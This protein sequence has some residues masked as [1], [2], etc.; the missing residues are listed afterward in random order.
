LRAGLAIPTPAEDHR[1]HGIAVAFSAAAIFLPGR[2]R[3]FMK[4]GMRVGCLGM[5][6]ILGGPGVTGSQIL[7]QDTAAETASKRKVKTR[8]QPAY[9]ALAKQLKVTG[10]VRIEVT[11]SPEGR[12]TNTKVVGGNPVLASSAVEAMKKWRFEPGPKETTELIEFE[13]SG[14]S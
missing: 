8:V 12:V 10:K 7:A 14:Q 6:L 2:R 9:P 1:A 5:A 3:A 11:I 13:F 4:F